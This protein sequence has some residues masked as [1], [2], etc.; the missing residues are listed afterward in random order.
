MFFMGASKRSKLGESQA[1]VSELK[2]HETNAT[3][4]DLSLLDIH[5]ALQS[6]E[7]TSIQQDVWVSEH[8]HSRIQ[9]NGVVEDVWYHGKLQDSPPMYKI[10]IKGELSEEGKRFD[11]SDKTFHVGFPPECKEQMMSITRGQPITI[12]ATLVFKPDREFKFQLTDLFDLI[13]PEIIKVDSS[14]DTSEKGGA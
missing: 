8:D 9:W 12:R 1:T 5:K 14:E 6:L 4:S 10:M 2:G 7:M 13:N 3:V 11:E